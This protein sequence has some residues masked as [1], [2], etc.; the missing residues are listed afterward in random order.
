VIKNKIHPI[1]TIGCTN[2]EMRAKFKSLF[3]VTLDEFPS[4]NASPS[5]TNQVDISFLQKSFEVIAS[6]LVSTQKSLSKLTEMQSKASESI[7]RLDKKV[8]PCYQ[9]MILVASSQG[10]VVPT[11]INKEAL[12]FFASENRT[13]AQL[14]LNSKL[15]SYNVQCTISPALSNLLGYG[16][17]LWTS[18]FSSSGLS[19]LVISPKEVFDNDPFYDGIVLDLSTKF[20]MSK[21]SL[22]KLT[23][24]QI[25]IPSTIEE[26]MERVRALFVLSEIFFGKASILV[27]NLNNFMDELAKNKLLLK[28]SLYSDD[29]FILK[30]LYDIDHRVYTGG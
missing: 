29:L 22:N 28:T 9:Q 16:H 3:A 10:S 27:S 4:N 14:Y 1:P 6:N 25:S 19:T 30:F 12:K 8:P 26:M 24:T 23:K 13:H 5:S 2:K 11:E 21:A 20:E 15:E 7:S 17:L 18:Y